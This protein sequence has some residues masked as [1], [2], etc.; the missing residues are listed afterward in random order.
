[1]AKVWR[2]YLLPFELN[3]GERDGGGVQP[4]EHLEFLWNQ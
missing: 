1:M 4:V 2:Q 3:L